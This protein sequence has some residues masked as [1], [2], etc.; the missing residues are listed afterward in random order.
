MDEDL[1]PR[2]HIPEWV[3]FLEESITS[4]R[5]IDYQSS[6]GLEYTHSMN[7]RSGPD[8]GGLRESATF[9]AGS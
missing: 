6:E 7:L 1:L 8:W 2:M 9:Y 4:I 5:T 3:T